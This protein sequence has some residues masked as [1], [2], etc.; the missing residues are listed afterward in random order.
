MASH[1]ISLYSSSISHFSGIKDGWYPIFFSFFNRFLYAIGNYQPSWR[2]ETLQIQGIY[3][4]EIRE[5]DWIYGQ[6]HVSWTVNFMKHLSPPPPP[7]PQT[8]GTCVCDIGPKNLFIIHISRICCW[9]YARHL[10]LKE[11]TLKQNVPFVIKIITIELLSMVLLT[12][13]CKYHHA[14]WTSCKENFVIGF[15]EIDSLLMMIREENIY[16]LWW[17][18][19]VL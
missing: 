7:T 1:S 14:Q 19:G 17:E 11:L 3:D 16:D 8:Y 18:F 10:V 4:S 13:K 12:M 6:R 9:K 15:K 2:I 5:I